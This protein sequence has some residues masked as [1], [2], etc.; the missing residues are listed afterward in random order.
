M[1]SW[2]NVQRFQ[3]PN[4]MNM[5]EC[6]RLYAYIRAANVPLHMCAQ[7]RVRSAC[8]LRSLISNFTVRILDRQGCKVYSCEQR[9]LIRLCGCADWFESSLGE[10]VRR[11]VFSRC[12][13]FCVVL[14]CVII[15]TQQAFTNLAK[16]E[17]SSIH[18]LKQVH[19][20]F[21]RKTARV[22]IIR[23]GLSFFFFFF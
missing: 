15:P 3:M 14:Y 9:R 10:H 7:R 23:N 2:S 6:C 4:A 19:S 16:C 8:T 11:Y 21:L 5:W 22:G 12:G 20:R 17:G 1:Y 13:Q 18:S